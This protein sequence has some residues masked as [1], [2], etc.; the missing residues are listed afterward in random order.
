MKINFDHSKT[1]LIE[2]LGLTE[3][4]VDEVCYFIIDLVVDA[5]ELKRSEI[6]ERVTKRFNGAQLLIAIG[7]ISK[8]SNIFDLSALEAL[9]LSLVL[10]LGHSAMSQ[11][12]TQQADV[13]DGGDY[14]A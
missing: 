5:G 10:G 4:H 2:A 1:N 7:F 11:N 12:G 6:I 13:I 3:K 14:D 8:V 9:K